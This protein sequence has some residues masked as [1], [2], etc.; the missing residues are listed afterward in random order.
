MMAAEVIEMDSKPVLVIGGTGKT[1]R[2]VVERLRALGRVARIGSRTAE[3]PFDWEDATTW[4]AALRGVA[5][6]YLTYYP[7][8]AI[9]GASERVGALADLAVR[10]GT[11]RIVLL[12]GRGEEGARRA[13][14]AVQDSRAEVTVLRCSWFL[15]NFSEGYLR[16]AIVAGEVTLPAGEVGEPFVDADDIAEVAVRTLTEGGHGGRV[17]E[18]T[19]PRLLTFAD[20]I[21]EIGAALGRPIRF[22]PVAV[23]RYGAMLRELGVPPDYVDLLVYLFG[24]VLDGRNA[25]LDDGVRRVLGRP[26]RDI[27][28]FARDAAA[29][30]AW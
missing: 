27:R 15:Q 23:E 17:Y 3:P 20:A 13:E 1:G 18:L 28:A 2:R 22:V 21:A 26:P 12:S 30:G 5:S 14:Q 16:D 25:R 24:E 29:G 10:S 9:P 4:E 11:R 8:L 19:G 7:D 6:V